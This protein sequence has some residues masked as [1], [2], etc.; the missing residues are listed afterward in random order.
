M[1]RSP[2]MGV[3]STTGS[4]CRVRSP[5]MMPL[6]I[7]EISMSATHQSASHSTLPTPAPGPAVTDH[8]AFRHTI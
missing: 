2:G 8:N 4:V 6:H 5:L 1:I 3:A 7:T